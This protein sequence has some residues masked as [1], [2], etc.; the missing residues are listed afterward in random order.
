ME[1]PPGEHEPTVV[2]RE[3]GLRVRAAMVSAGMVMAELAERTGY[4]TSRVSRQMAGR[5]RMSTVDVA[6]MLTL[7][8]WT[9]DR[10][11]PL[12]RLCEEGGTRDV[13]WLAPDQVGGS[14]HAHSR[15]LTR[16]VHVAP[17]VL[18]W[19]VQTDNYAAA[20]CTSSKQLTE[21]AAIRDVWRQRWHD[22]RLSTTVFLHEQ[23]LR[24]VVGDHTVM[25]EQI[26][27]LDGLSGERGLS[28]R[29]IPADAG[30]HAAVKGGFALLEFEKWRPLVYQDL[31]NGGVLAGTADAVEMAQ[32]IV[33]HLDATAFSE[34]ESR[35][36]L[37]RLM[38]TR[39]PGRGPCGRCRGR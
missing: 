22:G 29:F 10:Q 27:H 25:A 28:F 38:T 30:A 36:F 20:T 18:P 24:S 4:A 3:L 13:L 23:A 11:E 15:H 32:R 7:C 34:R 1:S 31:G 2:D 8:G 9:L 37:R 35:E 19:I 21:W 16:V 12:W 6:T 5:Q 26:A 17:T 14:L 39:P 33:R